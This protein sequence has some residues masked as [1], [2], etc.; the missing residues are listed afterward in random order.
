MLRDLLIRFTRMEEHWRTFYYSLGLILTLAGVGGVAMAMP[1][2][3][4]DGVRGPDN[5]CT[6]CCADCSCQVHYQPEPENI[7]N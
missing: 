5:C 6:V 1:D 2:T 3:I 7:I 4:P